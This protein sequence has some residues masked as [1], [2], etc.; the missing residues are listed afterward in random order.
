MDGRSG[1]TK[2]SRLFVKKK[3]SDCDVKH[4]GGSTSRRVPLREEGAARERVG[5]EMKRCEETG[6]A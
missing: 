5:E 2:R 1:A 4:G 3:K 6:A